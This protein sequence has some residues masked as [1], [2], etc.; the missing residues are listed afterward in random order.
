MLKYL[1][2]LAMSK[3]NTFLI[4]H[5]TGFLPDFSSVLQQSFHI[6]ER[7][8]FTNSIEISWNVTSNSAFYNISIFSHGILKFSNDLHCGVNIST[9]LKLVFMLTEIFN[10]MYFKIHNYYAI[11]KKNRVNLNIILRWKKASRIHK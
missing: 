5:T 2:K 1:K 7:T 6:K 4:Q 3:V 11:R 9:S 10:L 8:V